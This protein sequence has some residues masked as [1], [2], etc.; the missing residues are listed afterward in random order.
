MNS[1]MTGADTSNSSP[2]AGPPSGQRPNNGH[3]RL[4]WTLGI[5]LA[6]VV[7]AIAV[8]TILWIRGTARPVDMDDVVTP[9][10][11]TVPP[12]AAELRPPQGVYTYT[13]SGTDS[14]DKPPKSQAQGPEMPATVVHHPDGCWTFRIEY[15][16]NHWQ[17]WDYCTADGELI[18]QGGTTYQ[19]W[20][21]GVYVNESTTVFTCDEGVTIR[22]EQEAGDEWTQTCGG[23]ST[24]TEGT[25][26]SSG[27]F[28][29]V[30]DETL[31]IGDKLVVAHRYH[32]ERTTSGNQTGSESSDVW[33]AV[34]TGMPLRNERSIEARTSTIIGDVSYTEQGEFQLTDLT[35]R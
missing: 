9:T 27:P 25:A 20:D 18:E 6:V 35:P 17:T 19:R 12:K 5:V 22:A 15:S 2:N 4:W 3:R 10:G 33:F 30:G 34:D 24:G 21:F 1:G 29:Y 13:G 28:T 14:L 16:T 23:T 7:V 31:T 8:V 11:S 26:E 32:R